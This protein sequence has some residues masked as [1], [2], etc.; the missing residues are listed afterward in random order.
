MPGTE[1]DTTGNCFSFFLKY[2]E[3]SRNS[4]SGVFFCEQK[5]K[6]F[7]PFILKKSFFDLVA[8][9]IAVP[10]GAFRCQVKKGSMVF[11]SPKSFPPNFCRVA[12]AIDSAWRRAVLRLGG[13]N[14]C[15]TKKPCTLLSGDPLILEL[16]FCKRFR[17]FVLDSCLSAW[18]L[19]LLILFFGFLLFCLYAFLLLLVLFL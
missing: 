1:K 12:H 7:Q 13:P 14:G 19:F 10:S 18:L 8:F 11:Q 3:M 15:R 6:M 16:F 4:T 17:N 5:V 2:G 9:P